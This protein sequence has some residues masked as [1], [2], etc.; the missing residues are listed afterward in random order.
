ME[1]FDSI[2]GVAAAK[3][4]LIESLPSD[5]VAVLN[6]DDPLVSKFREAHRG[7]TITFGI[8]SPAD[9]RRRCPAHRSRREFQGGRRAFESALVGRH[10]VSN[11]LAGLAVASL[12]G[13]RPKQL[14]KW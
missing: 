5:G 9:S 6:A 4:E 13:I 10:S 3:R 12:Y 2:E 8:N 11:I 7:R 1:A 14:T